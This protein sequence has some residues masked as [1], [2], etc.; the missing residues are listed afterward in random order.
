MTWMRIAGA[1]WIGLAAMASLTA[2]AYP[3]ADDQPDARRE[4][5]GPQLV[6]SR[7]LIGAGVRLSADRRAR[8]GVART[9]AS[10]RAAAPDGEC[11]GS[12]VDL[13]V[14]TSTGKVFLAVAGR[15]RSASRSMRTLVPLHAGTWDDDRKQYVL[16]LSPAQLEALPRIDASWYGDDVTRA[17]DRGT[18]SLAKRVP[19]SRNTPRRPRELATR[20]SLRPVRARDG[21]VGVG[22]GLVVELESGTVAF[23]SVVPTSRA[24]RG[25]TYFVPWEALRCV[26]PERGRSPCIEIAIDRK[27]LAHAPR[28]AGDGMSDLRKPAMRQKIYAFYGVERP[29]FDSVADGKR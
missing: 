26:G 20:L 25:L 3:Q 27:R 28:G 23:L 16:Q 18:T 8:S 13:V 22:S 9:E 15:G 5:A 24:A 4:S 10:G 21:K 2:A 19:V 1:W 14:D 11:I 17:G 7:S 6:R 29:T 12:I